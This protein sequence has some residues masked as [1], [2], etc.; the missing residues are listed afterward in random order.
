MRR[1]TH[2]RCAHY[3]WTIPVLL[4]LHADNGAKF[5][6]LVNTLNVSRDALSR[7]LEDLIDSGLVERNKGYGHPLRPEYVLT[8]AGHKAAKKFS[9]LYL[10]LKKY[11]LEEVV[12]GS[13]WALPLIDCM[14][15]ERGFNELKK[16]LNATPR[17]IALTLKHLS[18]AGIVQR[19]LADGFPP[20]VSYELSKLGE[21]IRQKM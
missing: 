21:S 2:F 20:R 3:K 5:I 8:T 1:M 14:K 13:K 11:E 16:M 10:V 6:T 7:T 18:S 12:I 9:E 19:K 4:R 15:Q 17:A